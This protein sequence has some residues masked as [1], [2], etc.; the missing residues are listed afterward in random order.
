MKNTYIKEKYLINHE[1][2]KDEHFKDE[3]FLSEDFQMQSKHH[4]NGGDSDYIW[5]DSRLRT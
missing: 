2:F 5:K 3:E 4:G 1:D